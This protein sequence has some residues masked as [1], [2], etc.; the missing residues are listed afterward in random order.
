MSLLSAFFVAWRGVFGR[1]LDGRA[2]ESLPKSVE[3]QSIHES[4]PNF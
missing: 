4:L 3:S 1:L 2:I